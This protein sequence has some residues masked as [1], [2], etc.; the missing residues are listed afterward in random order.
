[1]SHVQEMTRGG[2]VGRVTATRRGRLVWAAMLGIVPVLGACE[3]DSYFDPS[4]T[5]R[6]EHTPTVV[7]ILERIASVERGDP[8]FVEATEVVPED[9]IPLPAEPTL[10]PGD[11]LDIRVRDFFRVGQEEPFQGLVDK[12]GMLVI[13]RLPPIRVQ[14]L[15]LTQARE[16]IA[17][18]IQQEGLLNDPV[19]TVIPLQVRQNTFSAFGSV[20]AP[21]TYYIPNADYR[22]LEALTAAGGWSEMVSEVYVIRQV[23]LSERITG[24]EGTAPTRPTQSAPGRPTQEPEEL[25][26]LIDELSRP[27]QGGNAPSP[28]VI[29]AG[30]GVGT[31]R[32]RQ[33]GEEVR[34]PVDLPDPGR[35]PTGEAGTPARARSGFNWVFLNGEW[36]RVAQVGE[37][38][39]P[40]AGR[41][42][43]LT[44][45]QL[46]T[47]RVIRIP[48]K[49][50]ISGS[51]KYNIVIRP[52]DIIRVPV[53]GQGIVY[54]GGQIARPGTYQ[55]PVSGQLTLLR[56]IDAAGG[57][58][59]IAI[60]ERVDLTRMVGPSSQAMVRVNL[61]AIAE[62]THP[63]IFLK[64][65][66][67]IT[68]GTNF[69]A[70]PLAVIRGG[71]RAS[72]GFGFLLDRNF[73]SDV[74]GAPPD[75]R[76][77]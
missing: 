66:D 7:P 40:G 24:E 23:A 12:R 62:G 16:E 68:I 32:V 50:L 3:A 2:R 65:D 29:G 33:P 41:G 45:E 60:P 76:L 67:R 30:A 46:V 10:G 38:S 74:F 54:L 71:F 15:T 9:L 47:Q 63:D 18:V 73:G 59:Q 64:P 53:A 35:A 6:W 8:D 52:G 21:G 39:G 26:D 56:A 55:I 77:R 25:I 43:D 14:G 48:M 58:N 70:Y 42:G 34:P 51:P 20:A 61:R 31:A 19:V 27:P 75:S 1:M 49:P 28:G 44:A 57:L 36:V 72:Y 17:R 37:P 22:L 13:P 11:I 5:G 69:W 4:V